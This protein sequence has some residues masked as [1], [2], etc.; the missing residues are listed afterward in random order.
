MKR[1][2]MGNVFAIKKGEAKDKYIDIYSTFKNTVAESHSDSINYGSDIA[3]RKLLVFVTS[4]EIAKN[5]GGSHHASTEDLS[6]IKRKDGETHEI[7]LEFI[8]Q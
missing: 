7:V 4:L 8:C 5:M 1:R 3:L 2:T 6:C